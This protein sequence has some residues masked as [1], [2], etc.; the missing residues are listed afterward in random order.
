MVLNNVQ[1]RLIGE[2]M[3]Y[4]KA[5]Y[6]EITLRKITESPGSSDRVWGI[7][8]GIDWHDDDKVMDF[9]EYLSLKEDDILVEY[10]Y[11]I[12]LMPVPI[13]GDKPCGT[14]FCRT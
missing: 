13:P 11:S 8:S 7:V 2:L 3:D 5:E 9:T 4:A 14:A 6:P 12:S 10:G 1:E